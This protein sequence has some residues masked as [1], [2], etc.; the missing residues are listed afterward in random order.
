VRRRRRRNAFDAPRNT[1][2]QVENLG[3][4]GGMRVKR[5]SDAISSES[6]TVAATS[7]STSAA[8]TTATT[9]ATAAATTAMSTTQQASNG[10]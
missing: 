7:S 10:H 4:L 5:K 3:V 8:T 2:A 6:K 9:T 1:E